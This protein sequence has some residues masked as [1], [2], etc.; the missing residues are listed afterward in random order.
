MKIDITPSANSIDDPHDSSDRQARQRRGA[1]HDSRS[2]ATDL[3]GRHHELETARFG[4]KGS[5][6][7]A[8]ADIQWGAACDEADGAAGGVQTSNG[9]VDVSEVTGD[10]TLQSSNGTIRADIRK[11]RFWAT[12]SNG[13]ITARLMETGFEPGAAGE[14]ER[15][16]RADAWMRRGRFMPARR[17]RRSRCGCRRRRVRTVDAHTSNSSITCDFDVSVHG[18]IDVEAAP[19]REQSG[20]GGPLLDLGTSNGSIK[21]LRM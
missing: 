14:L 9:T 8:F 16:H 1:V 6:A 21:L 12:T 15:A 17:T 4:W 19:A 18:G 13:S 10:T 3:S 5:R 20:M 7:I 11:G 2:E